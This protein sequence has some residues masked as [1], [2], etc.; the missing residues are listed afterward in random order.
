MDTHVEREFPAPPGD[1]NRRLTYGVGEAEFVEY[2][3]VERGDFSDNYLTVRNSSGNVIEY[4]TRTQDLTGV[5]GID[6]S[7]FSGWLDHLFVKPPVFRREL[8][9][10]ECFG[11]APSIGHFAETDGSITPRK[12][13]NLA[14]GHSSLEGVFRD[15]N[16]INGE[17]DLSAHE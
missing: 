7:L 12:E 6:P 13:P 2:I 10:D 9:H 3:G 5:V 16:A 15:L 4:D 1:E 11:L 17:C 14:G 8:H